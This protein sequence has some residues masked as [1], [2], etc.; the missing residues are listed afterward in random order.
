MNSL[1]KHIL[2]ADSDE[3]VLIQLEKLL[4]DEGFETTTASTTTE[5]MNL[6]R[7]SHFD[8]LL[9][10]D[11]PPEINC[12]RVLREFRPGEEAV[13]LLVL[14][15]LP[16]HPFAGAYLINLG[17]RKIVHKWRLREVR[18]AVQGLIATGF[19]NAAKSAVA[20]GL[21]VG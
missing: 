4:E 7:K 18:D 9:V 10:A 19:G 14:E 1:K 3:R 20:A 12:E 6:L 15:N 16:R 2:I 21:K 13:P 8:L 5:T 11:H 17:A